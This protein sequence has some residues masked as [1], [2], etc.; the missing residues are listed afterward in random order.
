MAFFVKNVVAFLLMTTL[1]G[2][3]LGAVY[4]VGDSAGWTA[5]GNVDY[6]KWASTKNF[7]VG[8][9]I[10]FNYNDQF[11]DVKEVALQ[12][13]QSCNA[14]SPMATYT[15][16]SDSI[17]LKN[18]GHHYFLCG[19]PGHCE[20]GQ[21]LDIMVTPV[22]LRPSANPNHVSSPSGSSSTLTAPALSI[23]SAPISP[24]FQALVAFVSLV[25]FVTSYFPY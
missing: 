24:I 2:V 22:S 3:S 8:D 20:A 11:H 13:F 5:M 6:E 23:N 16:G 4:R 12:D 17:T 9:V 15:T 10:V 18:L 14:A 21:K 25:I 7:H 19:V 1:F